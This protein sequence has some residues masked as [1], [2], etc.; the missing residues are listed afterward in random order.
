[1]P[2]RSRPGSQVVWLFPLPLAHMS[3]E[4]FYMANWCI[5]KDEV[6]AAPAPPAQTESC[7]GLTTAEPRLPPDYYYATGSAQM[8]R[9]FGNL[10]SDLE[11]FRFLP[12]REGTGN[13][14]V[15]AGRIRQ[16]STR[17]GRALF[18][19]MDVS[20]VR[21][22]SFDVDRRLPCLL[23]QTGWGGRAGLE[24]AKAVELLLSGRRPPPL[25]L[26]WSARWRALGGANASHHDLR[27]LRQ[28]ARSSSCPSSVQLCLCSD[29]DW[30][31]W[32]WRRTFP[33]AQVRAGASIVSSVS[34]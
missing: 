16:Q 14:K 12:V 21:D 7:H 26:Q 1:M 24:W 25:A 19:N 8:D 10:I 5:S 18:H 23:Q 9:F 27:Q 6:S 31:H 28:E 15:V 29:S 32:L 4:L 3:P 22:T 17:I 2:S 34:G 30:S 20:I 13:H 33:P 11:A